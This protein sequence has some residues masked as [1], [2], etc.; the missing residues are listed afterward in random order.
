MLGAM[1]RVVVP[2]LSPYVAHGRVMEVDVF[3]DL[4]YIENPTGAFYGLL[5]EGGVLTMF[6]QNGAG[7]KAGHC[8]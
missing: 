6:D 7:G 5:D 4:L 8:S 3:S 1:A 2:T